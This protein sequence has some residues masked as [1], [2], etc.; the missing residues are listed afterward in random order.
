[1]KTLLIPAFVALMA[2]PAFADAE[3][4][5]EKM[6]AQ[7]GD[8]STEQTMVVAKQALSGDDLD[9]RI[10]TGGPEI[11]SRAGGSISAGHQALADAMGVNASDFTVAELSAM[12]IG[13]YD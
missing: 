6:L 2:A 12:F 10:M 7:N 13:K 11:V 4:F 3:D 1:M 5:G 9:D 8:N